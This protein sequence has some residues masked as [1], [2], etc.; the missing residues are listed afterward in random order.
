MDGTLTDGQVTYAGNAEEANLELQSFC[1]RDGQGLVWLRR[2]GIQV[3]WITGRGCAATRRR[4]QEL[5]IVRLV[6]KSGPKD[7][8]LEGIQNELSL[9]P[10]RTLAMGDDL[11][12]LR[13]FAR[14]AVSAAPADAMASVLAAADL[15]TRAPGGRGAVREICDQLLDARS[16]GVDPRS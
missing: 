12:D 14:A 16:G 11:P 6:E 15:H 8:I 7:G 10:D 5:G 2:A 9:G 4:A 13:L 1:V 3:V